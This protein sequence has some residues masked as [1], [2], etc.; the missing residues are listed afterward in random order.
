MSFDMPIDEIAWAE[1]LGGNAQTMLTA[2]ERDIEEFLRDEAPSMK[3]GEVRDELENMLDEL[4][5]EAER[6]ASSNNLL[7]QYF[8]YAEDDFESLTGPLADAILRHYTPARKPVSG[9]VRSKGV[10]GRLKKSVSGSAGRGS[11]KTGSSSRKPKTAPKA[12]TRR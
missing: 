6:V 5:W 2:F 10:S 12:K 7:D 3:P 9:S 4:V 1:N 8:S 11:S